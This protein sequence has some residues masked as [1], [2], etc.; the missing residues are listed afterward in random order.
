MKRVTSLAIRLDT[1]IA[2]LRRSHLRSV[3]FQ[4]GMLHGKTVPL[5]DTLGERPMA[6]RAEFL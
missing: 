1:A 2:T 3:R 6:L 5:P 4:L